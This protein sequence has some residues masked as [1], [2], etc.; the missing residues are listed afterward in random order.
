M[1]ALSMIGCFLRLS[2]RSSPSTVKMLPVTLASNPQCGQTLV[3]TGRRQA[4]RGHSFGSRTLS[5]FDDCRGPAIIENV[6]VD[7][8]DKPEPNCGVAMVQDQAIVFALRW[9]QATTDGLDE[10]HFRFGRTRK[11]DASDIPIH[12][13]GENVHIAND[14]KVTAGEMLTDLLALLLLGEAIDVTGPHTSFLK[15]AFGCARHE[16]DS[17]RSTGLADHG[18]V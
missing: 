14:F 16:R 4:Q 18:H 9:A 11:N 12:A 3:W 5:R 17:R 2:S 15:F 6:V 13:Q 8:G 1:S 7:I 10:A